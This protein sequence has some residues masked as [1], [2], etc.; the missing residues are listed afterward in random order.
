MHARLIQV[1]KKKMVD[2]AK[3]VIILCPGDKVRREVVKKKIVTSTWEILESLYITKSLTHRLF[4][5]QQLHS[6]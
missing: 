4:L 3:N 1:E 5:K 2:K 6:F